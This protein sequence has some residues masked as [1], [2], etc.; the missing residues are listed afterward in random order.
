MSAD[1]GPK[2]AASGA[3]APETP[4]TK[5]QLKNEAK[6]KAKMEKYL[7]K[8]AALA[9][10]A[11]NASETPAGKVKKAKEK[12]TQPE[13]KPVFVNK[14]PVGEK[15]DMSQKMADSYDPAA[16]EAAWYAWWE[17]EGFFKPNDDDDSSSSS[18]SESKGK[19][20]ITTPPPNITGKL[21][22][23]HSMYI[24]IQDA[25]VRWNRMRGITTLFVPGSDHASISTQTVVENLLWKNEK[26]T[27]H[28]VGR[29]ALVNIIWDWTHKYRH[30]ITDQVKRMGGSYDWSR[31]RFTLD[32]VVSRATYESFVRLFDDGIIY[33]SNR[34]VN[35]CHHLNTSL[36]NLEV[37]Q[38]ELPGKTMMSIP[39]YRPEE[40]FEF[41]V[42]VHFAYDIEGS[43][44]RIVVATTR[45]ETMLGDTAV[46]VHPDDA[47]Y[48]KFHG[49]FVKHPFIDRRIPIITD[50]LAADMTFGTGAVKITPAHDMN[51]YEVGKR[52]NLEF[53]NLLN[54]DGTYNKNAGPYNGMLRFHV[55]KQIIEDLKSKGLYVDT[56]DNPMSVPIC[57]KSKD[58]IE[59]IMKPQWWVKCKP[60][61]APAMQVVRDGRLEIMP[62][63]SES[64]WFRW[65]GNIQDW[66]ISRQ[67]WWGHR[68]PAYFVRVAGRENDSDNMDHWVAGR[69]EAEAWKRAEAKFPGL[70]FELEQDP[71]VFDTWFS[72]GLWP[73]AV[74]GWPENTEDYRKY[75]P[76]SLLETGWDIIFY[77]VAR[78][79]M[80]GIYLTGE[81][82]FSRVFCHSL[83]RDAQ[84]RKMSK[85]LGNVIDPVDVIQGVSL[86]ELHSKLASGNLDPQEFEKAKK[87]QSMDFPEGIPECGTDALRFALCNCISGGRDVNLSIQ[88]VDG[89]RKFC[90]KLWN[91]TRFVL[92][93]LGDDFVPSSTAAPTGCESLAERW[94]LHR[95]NAAAR[96][97]ST[98]LTS[99]N[100][101]VASNAV[102]SFWLYD[103][104]DVYIEYIKPI[105]APDTDATARASA[106]QTLYTCLDQALKLLHPFMP[107]VTEELWQRLPRRASETAPSISVS[108]Y[109]EPRSD[110]ESSQAEA[111][112]EFV[113][114]V[115]AAGRSLA[116]GYNVLTKST[117]YVTSAK[118]TSYALILAQTDGIATMIPGCQS[119]VAL[120][121]GESVPAGCAVSS[122]SDEAAVHLL[123]R[124]QVDIDKEVGNIEKKISKAAK[125]KAD[126]EKKTHA[127]KYS[128][129][130]PE[131]VRESNAAKLSN[132]DAEIEALQKAITTFLILKDGN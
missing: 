4:L 112:F 114:S 70:S 111:E 42:L 19:F 18:G 132:Y 54:D 97:V 1:S 105:T 39:G 81:V 74:M 102:Y 46:V 59:F 82:P 8:Q 130:V 87:S 98:A 106:Q 116:A 48:K 121:P 13:S 118:D 108:A 69:D 20:I 107:F 86:Q 128:E 9:A 3:T 99:M 33:R 17:K 85:S 103:L 43:S 35:W 15:K 125:L 90:N 52:H 113:A 65:L 129:V 83:V 55:R 50:A 60:L 7:A 68:I 47:R 22:I 71:D 95:L 2:P 73:F 96:D 100:F 51:D 84:G 76:T 56:V 12:K 24:S 80:L 53:I 123:V 63:S 110:Y 131:S 126:L 26:K 120:K 21:H 45:I 28:D 14:T 122:I 79:V 34:L 38:I 49:K 16:V 62:A 6:R 101:M 29:E 104:C 127:P 88:R 109:P 91:A 72:S 115:A 36:S 11:D 37:E 23:G 10:A 89:Y 67:L 44:D 27:R 117:F 64:E 40:K 66:C 94:I 31:E 61:A 75:Y 58:V 32:E 30:T 25:L 78:M 93:K 57:T 124:G 119:V 77:W 41:G 92:I 5:N